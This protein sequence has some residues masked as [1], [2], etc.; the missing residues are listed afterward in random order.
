MKTL[1]AVL[2]LSVCSFAA[3]TPSDAKPLTELQREKLLRLQIQQQEINARYQS[4]LAPVQKELAAVAAEVC[5]TVGIPKDN[6]SECRPDL[7]VTDKFKFGSVWREKPKPVATET[8]TSGS[9]GAGSGNTQPAP[10]KQP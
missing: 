10:V 2:S 3:D 1:F 8:P 4:E 9:N 6:L 5:A 7:T